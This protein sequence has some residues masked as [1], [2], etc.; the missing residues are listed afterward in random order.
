MKAMTVPA[1]ICIFALLAC[2][3]A[4]TLAGDVTPV[5]DDREC[6]VCPADYKGAQLG[7]PLA[8]PWLC[9]YSDL[10]L[11]MRCEPVACDDYVVPVCEPVP[12]ESQGLER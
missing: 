4:V 3:D 10:D 8:L 11:V 12:V 7:D 6:Y 9:E 1:L 5:W 2:G